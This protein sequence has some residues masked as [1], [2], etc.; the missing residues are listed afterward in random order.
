MVG[1][2]SP[3]LASKSVAMVSLDLT[4]KM[5]AMVSPGWPQNR[6]HEF[7]SLGLKTISSGLMI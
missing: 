6:W 7:F 1:M 2:V 3:D 4:S 5:V